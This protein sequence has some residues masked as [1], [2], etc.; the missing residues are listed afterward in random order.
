M[1]HQPLPVPYFA[2]IPL[3][4]V[5]VYHPVR[6]HSEEKE[7]SADAVKLVEQQLAAYNSHDLEAFLQ[8]YAANVK[9]LEFPDKELMSGKEAMRKSYGKYFE[10]NPDVKAQIAKRIVQGDMVI[11]HEMVTATRLN[12]KA[13]AIYQIK[14][15][16]IARVWF[17]R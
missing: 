6:V 14:E 8:P 4:M 1:K 16:K 13:I 17:I 7:V 15:G 5:L 9:I 11:D 12:F 10:N 2:W 3:L